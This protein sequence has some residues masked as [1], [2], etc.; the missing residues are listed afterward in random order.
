MGKARYILFLIALFLS[1]SMIIADG[2]IIPAVN[3]LYEMFPDDEALVNFI[4]TGDYL[5]VIFLSTLAGKLCRYVSK[6]TLI[7]FGGIMMSVGG[8]FMM[9][10]PNPLF[11]CFMRFLQSFGIA[12]TQVCGVSLIADVFDEKQRDRITGFY[13]AAMYMLGAVMGPIAGR[14]AAISIPDVCDLFWMFVPITIM[15]AIFFPSKVKGASKQDDEASVRAVDATDD[16]SARAEQLEVPDVV[17]DAVRIPS[18]GRERLHRGRAF[19]VI[20][21]CFTVMYYVLT[22]RLVYTSVYLAEN[23]LGNSVDA[24]NLEAVYTL[25]SFIGC[26]VTVWIASKLKSMTLPVAF[27]CYLVA[28]IILYLF[29]YLT[30]CFIAYVLC[31]LGLGIMQTYIYARVPSLVPAPLIESSVAILVSGT[32]LTSFIS[33]YLVS[34][35]MA[36]MGTAL[37]TDTFIIPAIATTIVVAVSLIE[38]PRWRKIHAIN[39]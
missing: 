20:A 1:S 7:V 21:V 28:F 33:S 8:I 31:G 35:A 25:S 19:W 9:A 22:V 39:S 24:G 13:Y 17:V 37:V 3:G 30:T 4:V 12:F 15:V 5:L 29:P 10:V 32:A 38:Q 18:S 36:A 23:G 16:E 6:K 26:I 27:G 11:M 14:L 34:A 2:I